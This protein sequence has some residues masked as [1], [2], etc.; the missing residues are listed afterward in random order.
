MLV[1]RI[2]HEER[3]ETGESRDVIPEQKFLIH[4]LKEAPKKNHKIVYKLLPLTL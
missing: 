3:A 4:Y 1:E 2:A